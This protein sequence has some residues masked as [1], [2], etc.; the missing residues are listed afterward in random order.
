MHFIAEW[1]NVP[2]EDRKEPNGEKGELV[3]TNMY[4]GACTLE[5]CVHKCKL[6]SI[7]KC[8]IKFI[9]TLCIIMHALE[10][11]PTRL[12]RFFGFSQ[13]ML[14]QFEPKPGMSVA[15]HVLA[16]SEYY[17]NIWISQL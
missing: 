14:L 3:D 11:D 16:S 13:I 12:V 2:E 10:V 8:Y 15:V 7:V 9:V 1:Y 4:V 5:A 17:K 6:H